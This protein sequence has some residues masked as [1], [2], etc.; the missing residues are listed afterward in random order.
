M[1]LILPLLCITSLSIFKRVGVFGSIGF[2]H[3]P[4][5]RNSLTWIHILAVM[6][7]FLVGN[8]IGTILVPPPI[9][10]NAIWNSWTLIASDTVGK[11]LGIA[12]ILYIARRAF[13][14]HIGQAGGLG[15]NWR[16]LPAGL[17]RGLLAYVLLFP[18]LINV[19][20]IVTLLLKSA[21]AAPEPVHP[22]IKELASHPAPL[23]Q[24][25]LALLACVSA[26]IGEELFFRGI[27]QSYLVE[28]FARLGNRP[29]RSAVW[30]ALDTQAESPSISRTDTSANAPE[31]PSVKPP[32]T[33]VGNLDAACE[34][35]IP[36]PALDRFSASQPTVP[37]LQSAEDTRAAELL[38]IRP[39]HRWAG[40]L[41]TAA[42]FAAVHMLMAPGAADW[43]PVL[44][45]LGIGLGYL[46]ERTGNLWSDMT[47]HA[48]FNTVSVLY[49][50]F[51]GLPKPGHS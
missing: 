40:I 23:H 29:A 45:L 34:N 7:I 6:G 44:F 47:L 1:N 17:W 9:A 21:H 11:I 4:Q 26:P 13:I 27:I 20:V 5:R 18:L 31:K 22:L 25:A 37:A 39:V 16:R 42:I 24:W 3:A 2:V 36:A 30:P 48:T 43:F 19:A 38:S 32:E 50:T 10:K 14:G 15:W 12:A 49:I 46:Y 8:L 35:S 51:H 41:I 28:R 33:T